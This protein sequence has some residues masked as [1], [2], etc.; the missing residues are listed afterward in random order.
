MANRLNLAAYYLIGL[1]FLVYGG[2]RLFGGSLA[3]AHIM[4]WRESPMGAEVEGELVKA[5]PQLSEKAIIDI[6][7]EAYL[8]WSLLM[9]V[10][11]TLGALLAL[12]RR[13]IGLVLIGGYYV[14]FGLMFVN[15]LAFNAKL[16]HFGIGVAMLALMVFLAEKLSHPA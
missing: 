10:V 1:G 4:R 6:P 16:L 2:A 12:F 9:G 15:Y 14:L 7:I 3:F 13:R 5:W 11:L 8:G